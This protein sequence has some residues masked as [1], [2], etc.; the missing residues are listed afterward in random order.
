MLLISVI[1]VYPRSAAPSFSLLCSPAAPGGFLLGALA[2]LRE[3]FP[4][5]LFLP[6]VLATLRPTH[7]PAAVGPGGGHLKGLVAKTAGVFIGPAPPGR[8][9][10]RVMAVAGIQQRRHRLGTQAFH[11][12][13]IFH[14]GPAIRGAQVLVPAPLGA[15]FARG[16]RLGFRFR[17]DGVG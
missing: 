9:P 3:I 6:A 16:D 11:P 5:A 15:G 12:A 7:L 13:K 4:V 17:P 1:E 14:P 8:L 2:P 10:L